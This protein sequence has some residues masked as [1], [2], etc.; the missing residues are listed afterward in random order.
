MII[1]TIVMVKSNL[2]IIHQLTL[3]NFLQ[4][5]GQLEFEE[6]VQMIRLAISEWNMEQLIR[7]AF[8]VFDLN[9]DGFITCDDLR[10]S[11][12]R[13]TEVELTNKEVQEMIAEASDADKDGMVNFE[14]FRNFVRDR[15]AFDRKE[16]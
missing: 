15:F 16:E 7:Y 11:Y 12:K 14:E 10:V 9:K 8:A 5:K 6:F 2:A 3:T 1:D 4:P 13:V